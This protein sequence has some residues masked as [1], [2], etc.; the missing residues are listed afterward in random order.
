[1]CRGNVGCG[2]RG[3][4]TGNKAA[5]KP[6][7][8]SSCPAGGGRSFPGLPL[9]G[10]AAPP[11]VYV[12]RTRGAGGVLA[13][14]NPKTV[15]AGHK[16]KSGIYCSLEQRKTHRLRGGFIR[17]HRAIGMVCLLETSSALKTTLKTL[18]L[19]ACGVRPAVLTSSHG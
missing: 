10:R 7:A 5:R 16:P 17:M 9:W 3:R 1:M 6:P 4:P 19:T 11:Q 13:H 14:D 18:R 12:N 8:P 15:C 2:Q